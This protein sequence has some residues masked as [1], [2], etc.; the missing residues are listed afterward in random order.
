ILSVSRTLLPCR[1]PAPGRRLPGLA[2]AS[3]TGGKTHTGT[4]AGGFSGMGRCRDGADE[5]TAAEQFAGAAPLPAAG[6]ADSQ[7]RPAAAA[8]RHVA[9][10][11]PVP[12]L[13]PHGDP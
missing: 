4:P 12:W 10:G 9:H 8:I 6:S 11:D 1:R 3:R 5:A 7:P 13:Y 2:R